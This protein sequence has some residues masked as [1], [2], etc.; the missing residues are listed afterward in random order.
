MK[1][2]SRKK[3][4]RSSLEI[5]E[6]V[7]VLSERLNKKD[8]PGKFYKNTENKIFLIETEYLQFLIEV[9]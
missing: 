5:G 4:L 8:A 7:F 1:I 2:D 6:K 9:K 3:R